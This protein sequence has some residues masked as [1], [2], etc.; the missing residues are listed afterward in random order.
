MDSILSFALPRG[1]ETAAAALH[2][3]YPAAG[4]EAYGALDEPIVV[5]A[6]PA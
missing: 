2:L 4:T 1:R 3:L 5:N 6:E